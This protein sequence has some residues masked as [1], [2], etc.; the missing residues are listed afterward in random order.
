MMHK[1][2]LSALVY[3]AA[4]FAAAFV[5]GMLRVLLVA[6]RLG[7]LAAVALELPV[8]LCLSWLVA[9]R[10]LRRWPLTGRGQR[11]A[12]GGLAFGCLMALELFLATRLF[13]RPLDGV[14]AAM[15]TLPGLVGLAGQIGFA[16]VPALRGQPAG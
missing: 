1:I 15:T 5:L 2:A 11:L 6:P 14:L 9:G 4:V 3:V 8:V 7:E 13:G 10:V 16:L 12:M